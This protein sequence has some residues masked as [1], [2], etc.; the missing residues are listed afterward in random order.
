MFVPYGDKPIRNPSIKLMKTQVSKLYNDKKKLVTEN[1]KLKNQIKTQKKVLDNEID[2]GDGWREEANDC[3]YGANKLKKQLEKLKLELANEIDTGDGWREDA[4]D[5]KIKMKKCNTKLKRIKEIEQM[6]QRNKELDTR[7][8]HL[9]EFVVQDLNKPKK[10]KNTGGLATWQVFL[11]N[12]RSQ[13]PNMPYREAQRNA[14]VL[15]KK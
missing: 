2:T 8:K 12:Y 15:F 6:M 4:T 3:K 9:N 1:N 7:D 11:N 14:S 10:K 13:N 5:Y